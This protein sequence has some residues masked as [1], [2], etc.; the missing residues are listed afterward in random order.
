MNKKCVFHT[1]S[2]KKANDV[3]DACLRL[4]PCPCQIM[5]ERK[6]VLVGPKRPKLLDLSIME[7]KGMIDFWARKDAHTFLLDEIQPSGQFYSKVFLNNVKFTT[8]EF[9][10]FQRSSI[11]QE[12][13]LISRG[14]LKKIFIHEKRGDINIF[15]VIEC[16]LDINYSI[17]EISGMH[18]I[19]KSQRSNCGLI[20]E[21]INCIKH[22]FFWLS[23]SSDDK[24]FLYETSGLEVRKRLLLPGKIGCI[25]PWLEK[26]DLVLAKLS[27]TS[28]C[29]AFV[30]DVDTNHK[31]ALLAW[32]DEHH[33][34]AWV[35]WKHV[36]LVVQ[37]GCLD[38]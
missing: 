30:R 1:S 11:S 27:E 32:V 23:T 28:N 21:P 2:E 24:D 4:S 9:V 16:L 7:K 10:V 25:P 38:I 33:G 35:D 36:Y 14:R 20:I 22:K 31:R 37:E 3:W 18:A 17:D 5:I 13:E 6:G 26:G 12:E 15:A 29:N 19:Q 8:G 34:E